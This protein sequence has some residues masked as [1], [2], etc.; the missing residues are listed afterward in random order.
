MQTTAKTATS[1]GQ[2]DSTLRYR[3]RRIAGQAL[4]C[5]H[6]LAD[7]RVGDDQPSSREAIARWTSWEP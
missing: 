6:P 7:G 5:W 1:V 3:A 4:A 2:A